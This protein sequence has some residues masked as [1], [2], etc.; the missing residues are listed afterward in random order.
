MENTGVVHGIPENTGGGHGSMENTGVVHGIPENTGGGHGIAENTGGERWITENIEGGHGSMEN[1][2]GGRG[3]TE[4]IEGGHGITSAHVAVL[5]LFHLLFSAAARHEEASAV[6]ALLLRARGYDDD[7][8]ILTPTGYLP[9]NTAADTARSAHSTQPALRLHRA[10]PRVEDTPSQTRRPHDDDFTPERHLHTPVQRG[11]SPERHT[12]VGTA[13]PTTTDTGNIAPQRTYPQDGQ[14]LASLSTRIQLLDTAI[15]FSLLASHRRALLE[16]KK[17]HALTKDK[18]TPTRVNS[19]GLTHTSNG[20]GVSG[21]VVRAEAGAAAALNRSHALTHNT[22]APTTNTPNGEGVS[23]A[24]VGAENSSHELTHD[25]KRTTTN[26]PNGEGISGSVMWAEAGAAAAMAA[27]F[28]LREEQE[29]A[30]GETELDNPGELISIYLCGLLKIVYIYICMCMYA[31][32][33][34]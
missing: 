32:I 10:A 27:A 11:Q 12:A 24:V 19:V 34:T 21:P 28:K 30:A 20:E 25:T 16:S 13:A 3:I 9:P 1:T 29:A 4:N 26:T 2:G 17:E 31:Y 8:A 18:K 23:G 15:L 33:H 14:E 22:K 6:C 5:S 7:D